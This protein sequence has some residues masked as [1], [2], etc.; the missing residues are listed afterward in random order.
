M[1]GGAADN[2][3]HPSSSLEGP[4][5]IKPGVSVNPLKVERKGVNSVLLSMYSFKIIDSITL[6]RQRWQVCD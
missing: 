4:R 2:D 5:K 3:R 6:F 1:C